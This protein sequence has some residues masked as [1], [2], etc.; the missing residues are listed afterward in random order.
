MVDELRL[1]DRLAIILPFKMTLVFLFL[2]FT[3]ALSV[4]IILIFDRGAD[5]NNDNGN[6]DFRTRHTQPL[7]QPLPSVIHEYLQEYDRYRAFLCGQ[8]T[9]TSDKTSLLK[10]W[11]ENWDRLS[12]TKEQDKGSND[13]L[14][15]WTLQ[16]SLTN[17]SKVETMK[18]SRLDEALADRTSQGCNLKR[19]RRWY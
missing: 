10:D 15:A 8:H 7:D 18:G 19:P 3:V 5:H 12:A 13:L 4:S 14:P 1:H 11:N 17:C 6:R 9:E 2:M 16:L